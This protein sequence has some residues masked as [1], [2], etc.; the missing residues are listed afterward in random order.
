MFLTGKVAIITGAS[1]PN[2]I[3]R[4]ISIALARQ[5]ADI[6]IGDLSP[7]MAQASTLVD[8]IENLGRRAVALPIDV[9]SAAEADNLVS[10]ALDKLGRI[11]ILVNNAGITR[12]SILVR[13]KEEDWDSVLAV[14]LK[15]VFNCTK[16]VIKPML[17]VKGGK[18]VNIAS[19]VGLIGNVSQANY[20]ASKAGVIGFTKS[21]ARE[22][23]SRSIN[24]NA[25]A[26]GFIQTDMTHLLSDDAKERLMSQVPMGE[27][28]TPDDVANAVVFLCSDMASYITG[29]VLN[30][31]GGMVM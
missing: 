7:L 30:V 29:Q 23:A 21:V 25:I 13:M 16:A 6:V 28:G 1:K 17:R 27:C 19:V 5:G 11:D 10:A 12:D 8:E 31:D 2:G 14:N 26:P 3:G 24:V 9:T 20:S 15:G 18:I 4:A 22:L